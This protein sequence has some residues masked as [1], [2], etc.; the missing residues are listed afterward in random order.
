MTASPDSFA[1]PAS[2]SSPS[3]PPSPAPPACGQRPLI[4]RR[5]IQ[6][7]FIGPDPD[8]PSARPLQPGQVR[9]AIDSF[10][11]T[12]NNL[13][14]AAFGEAM[15]YWQFFPSGQEGLGCLPVWGFATVCESGVEGVQVGRR[16]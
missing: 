7:A 1:A 15:Q 5:H 10:S 3:A 8:A 14:Y 2:A 12:A 6:E 9:L 4:Q 13:T 16:V 11:L